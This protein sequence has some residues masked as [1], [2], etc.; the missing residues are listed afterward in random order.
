[1]TDPARPAPHLLNVSEAAQRL[2]VSVSFLNKL[3]LSRDGPTFLKL[4]T[5][6]A[7]DPTDLVAWLDRRR[8]KSTSEAGSGA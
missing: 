8:R 4:G 1:M 2:G 6:V 5:R 7:Y 3:R